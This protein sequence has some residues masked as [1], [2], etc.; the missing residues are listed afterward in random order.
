MRY[1]LRL[2]LVV[3]EVYDTML[4]YVIS[5]MYLLPFSAVRGLV[6]GLLTYDKNRACFALNRTRVVDVY[7]YVRGHALRRYEPT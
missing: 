5:H 6:I 4:I 2:S 1:N 3:I 7:I